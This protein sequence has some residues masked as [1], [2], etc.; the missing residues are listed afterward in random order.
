[1]FALEAAAHLHFPPFML[2]QSYPLSSKLHINPNIPHVRRTT[3]RLNCLGRGWDKH[4]VVAYNSSMVAVGIDALRAPACC[5]LKQFRPFRSG[6]ARS[7]TVKAVNTLPCVD[8]QI[9]RRQTLQGLLLLTASTLM[10]QQ[11]LAA[12]KSAEVGRWVDSSAES[13]QGVCV[14]LSC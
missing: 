3:F 2:Y 1:M 13:D 14:S 8:E 4:I 11:V 7:P 10:P 6:K 12:G 5:K 9:S